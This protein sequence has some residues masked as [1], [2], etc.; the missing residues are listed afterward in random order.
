MGAMVLTVP[1]GGHSSADST[2]LSVLLT[3]PAQSLACGG[4]VAFPTE[5]VYGI[6]AD[7]LDDTAIRRVFAAKGRPADNPLIVH[8]ADASWIDR[9]VAEV[10]PLAAALMKAF[11]PGPL[12]M[13][14]R[15]RPAV[16]SVTT[17]GLVTVAVRV[18]DHVLA[19]TLIGL[20]DT[21]VSAPSANISGRPSATTAA[22]VRA[23]LGQRIDWII[24]G[25]PC[26]LGIESTV[27][28]AR[29]ARPVV[30]REGGVTREML[31]LAER[32]PGRG[33]PGPASGRS[34][35]TAHPHYQPTAQVVL[36]PI[37]QG[38][39]V[40][41]RLADRRQ[42]GLLAPQG[43]DLD[44]RVQVLGLPLGAE[45][46]AAVMYQALRETDT[47]GL[48]IIVVEEVPDNGLG[49]AVMDRLRRASQS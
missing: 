23:D 35:G 38:V 7:A 41:N 1:V 16:P 29:G 47:R 14:L 32:A 18:P 27:V 48:D 28:D 15:A 26:R 19:R 40:A 4:L 46:L 45:E 11:W 20:A 12:T 43:H 6:G 30:L 39:A 8:L 33:D 36:A 10:T 13:V 44:P 24:D 5:T 2:D 25:G 17:G 42:V 21:P 37:G 9:V 34:P 22:H 49:A 31:G 3:E